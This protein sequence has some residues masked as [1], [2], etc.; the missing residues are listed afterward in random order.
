MHLAA[1]AGGRER[2]VTAPV[3]RR[4]IARPS[5]SIVALRA[6]R[7]VVAYVGTAA[8]ALAI[9][10]A[11]AGGGHDSAVAAALRCRVVA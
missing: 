6:Q 1:L 4:G 5:T 3:R 7:V 11:A 8:V 9:A 2:A 10:S